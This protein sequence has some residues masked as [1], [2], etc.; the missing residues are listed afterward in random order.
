MTTERIML[1]ESAYIDT[2]VADKA[3]KY[4]RKAILVIP[5][6]GYGGLCTATEGEPVA[7]AFI[8]HGFNAFVLKYSVAGEKTFP[9]QLIQASKAIKHIR[10][11]AQNYGI[12]KDEIYVVGFS[13][14]GHLAATVAT[15]W[16]KK[17]IY[18]EIDMPYG[19]NKPKGVMLVYP[20]VSA[21]SEYT[22]KRSFNN[23]LGT[24]N[25][26]G[27]QLNEVSIELNVTEDACPAYIVHSANDT[28]VPVE[29]SLML[30]AK[31]SKHN[32]PF[33]LHIYPEGEHAFALGNKITEFGDEQHSKE[34]L[35]DWVKNAVRWTNHI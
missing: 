4:I 6:G 3:S 5:G 16:N 33:E 12:N 24:E 15:M 30:A 23:L 11:N 26:T 27:E 22:H 17:E 10:D 14:G 9:A 19:Y 35:S 21:V 13:A 29:N 8:P 28:C 32:I 7:L 20:V 25:P 1:D 2:Y 34:G 18:D 31:Y